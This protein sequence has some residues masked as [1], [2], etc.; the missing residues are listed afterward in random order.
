MHKAMRSDSTA[1]GLAVTSSATAVGDRG[2]RSISR[3]KSPSS[4][5]L[6]RAPLPLPRVPQRPGA[7]PAETVRPTTCPLAG[8]NFEQHPLC[9]CLKPIQCSAVSPVRDAQLRAAMKPRAPS[10]R[11]SS[12]SSNS[13]RRRVPWW[14]AIKNRPHSAGIDGTLVS[15]AA[16]L[17]VLHVFLSFSNTP[18][19]PLLLR[20]DANARIEDVIICCLGKLPAADAAM[21]PISVPANFQ[22]SFSSPASP[23]DP[24]P[25]RPNPL[26]F[27]TP[28]RLLQPPFSF[29]LDLVELP[30]GSS[31]FLRDRVESVHRSRQARAEHLEYMLHL[32][33]KRA[34]AQDEVIR[35]G[36]SL[37]TQTD[38]LLK[39][40]SRPL[41]DQQE[42]IGLLRKQ[43]VAMTHTN[44][45][46]QGE[47]AKA[48]GYP[49]DWKDWYQ[50]D[51]PDLPLPPGKIF[52]PL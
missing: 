50:K 34:E 16:D 13:S 2:S 51:V 31:Q 25:S 19:V 48:L 38:R 5:G 40:S 11:V 6:R 32:E 8:S 29:V 12:G 49:T 14:I 9:D 37:R 18:S 1:T 27:D 44:A 7:V 36:D 26:R 42:L 23:G 46:H 21:L 39:G 43:E 3:S 52:P 47:I 28:M 45:E 4:P 15:T 33:A 20:L 22:I 35:M 24:D 41:T 17:Y 30:R 10:S